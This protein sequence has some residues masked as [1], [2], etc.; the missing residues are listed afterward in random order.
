VPEVVAVAVRAVLGRWGEDLAVRH[1]EAAG[2]EV[3]S[4]NW[5]CREGEID[6]VARAGSVICFVEVK[7]RSG[8]AFGEPAEAVSWQKAQRLRR[9]AGRWLAVHRPQHWSGLRFDV[10]SVVRAPDGPQLT[11]LEGAF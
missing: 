1:L 7:T 11:H 5:R 2:Y 9:L 4:R 10:V 6:V 8:T 3:L